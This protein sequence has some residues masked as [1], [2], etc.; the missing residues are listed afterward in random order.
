MAV[1][2]AHYRA[3]GEPWAKLVVFLVAVTEESANRTAMVE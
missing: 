1:G 2:A 3:A